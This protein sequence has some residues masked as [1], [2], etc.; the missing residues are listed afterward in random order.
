[1]EY[2]AGASCCGLYGQ[3]FVVNLGVFGSCEIL[4]PSLSLVLF[5]L[6]LVSRLNGRSLRFLSR[7]ASITRAAEANN[8]KSGAKRPSN[9]D[10]MPRL[11]FYTEDGTGGA[12][13]ANDTTSPLANLSGFSC[14][15]LDPCVPRLVK[16][17]PDP[18][19]DGIRGDW[20]VSAPS[21]APTLVLKLW[22]WPEL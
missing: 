13:A 19:R 15:P 7:R 8:Q 2:E 6:L 1:M 4:A 17:S 3:D 21:A 22:N 14:V 11:G 10:S 12:N 9:P 16:G 5:L 20:P 18:L